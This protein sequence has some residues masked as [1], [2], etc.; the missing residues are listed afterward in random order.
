[1]GGIPNAIFKTAPQN[2]RDVTR[3]L[4]N[5]MLETVLFPRPSAK[6]IAIPL[7]KTDDRQEPNISV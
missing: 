6:I 5:T 3:N 7:V 2:I 1:M 4:F